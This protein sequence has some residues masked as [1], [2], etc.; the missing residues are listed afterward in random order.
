MDDSP[1]TAGTG[2]SEVER[3]GD[4]VAVLT[5][6][7][8]AFKKLA[9]ESREQECSQRLPLSW[10]SAYA[11]AWDLPLDRYYPH[12]RQQDQKLHSRKIGLFR[13]SNSC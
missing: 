7:L 8:S 6:I 4:D 12:Q 3:A 11:R 13:Q 10:A 1:D 5:E 9:P 2:A